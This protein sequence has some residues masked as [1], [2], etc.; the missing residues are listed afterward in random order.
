MNQPDQQDKIRALEDEIARLK[1]ALEARESEISTLKAMVDQDMFL[2]LLNR[3]AFDREFTRAWSAAKRY[4]FP[5]S[6]I[7]IDLDNMKQINDEFGHEA[8]DKALREVAK[9]LLEN[10]RQSDLTGRLGGDEFGV[11]MMQADAGAAQRKAAE[12]AQLVAETQINTQSRRISLSV[13]YGVAGGA[14]DGSVSAIIR[15]AD[16]RMYEMKQ[17]GG[18]DSPEYQSG[19]RR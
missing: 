6:L 13:S 10:C 5:V 19:P 17:S 4:K 11:L 15:T 14:G 1:S 2:P 3:R 16:R 7:Y 9:V 8:G 18:R 12:L